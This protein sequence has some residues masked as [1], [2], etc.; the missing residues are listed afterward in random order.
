LTRDYYLPDGT[1]IEDLSTVSQNQRFVVVLTV[2][3]DQLGSG[4]YVVA[5]PLPAGFE[6]ENPDL[7]SGGVADLGWLSVSTPTH[8]EARTEQYIAAFTY[9]SEPAVFSTAYMVRAV[10]PGTFVHPGT[11][12]EDMYRPELRANLGAATIE[13]TATGP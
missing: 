3:P 13:V 12:I 4:Q 5:D 11:T 9:G 6:I 2:D 7:S 10:S 8:V 1:L